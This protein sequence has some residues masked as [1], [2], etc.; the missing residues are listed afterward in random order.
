MLELW[1]DFRVTPVWGICSGIKHHLKLQGKETWRINQIITF[2]GRQT[3][4]VFKF[5][6]ATA[7]WEIM[8]TWPFSLPCGVICGQFWCE[9]A[10]KSYEK[11][12]SYLRSADIECQ[13][14]CWELGARWLS[15]RNSLH[16]LWTGWHQRSILLVKVVV[17]GKKKKKRMDATPALCHTFIYLKK[18][19]LFSSVRNPSKRKLFDD[20]DEKKNEQKSSK[21]YGQISS[22]W[23]LL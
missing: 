9:S 2:L 14:G 7:L 6:P 8:D 12:C 3:C 11:P 1:E 18:K 19:S 15:C 20:N 4:L 13:T 21:K 10:D 17:D 16:G 22:W 5:K 23:F